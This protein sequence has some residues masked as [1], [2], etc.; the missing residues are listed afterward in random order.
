MYKFFDE[1]RN[2]EHYLV[3]EE[4]VRDNTVN[5]K[6]IFIK[7]QVQDF[8]SMSLNCDA[9]WIGRLGEI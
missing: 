4:E 2:Q 3:S 1:S 7:K 9:N 8:C 5:S 6:F